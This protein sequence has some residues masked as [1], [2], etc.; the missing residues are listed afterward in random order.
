MRYV[1]LRYIDASGKMVEECYDYDCYDILNRLIPEKE[2]AY[3]QLQNKDEI[4]SL[5]EKEQMND[6]S[7]PFDELIKIKQLLDMGI[8]TEEE[9]T[10]TKRRLLGI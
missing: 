2:Y 1:V 4:Q 10:A 8:I 3:V 5:S 6:S 9:F 7:I